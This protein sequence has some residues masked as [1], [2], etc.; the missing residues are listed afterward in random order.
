M[1]DYLGYGPDVDGEQPSIWRKPGDGSTPSVPATSGMYLAAH[2]DGN[3]AVV[4]V[5]WQAG[6][7]DV[8][9][10]GAGGTVDLRPAAGR[11]SI[12]AVITLASGDAVVLDKATR[13]VTATAADESAYAPTYTVATFREVRRYK[14]EADVPASVADGSTGILAVIP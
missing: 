12:R 6:A 7:V 11:G 4:S 2:L 14:S 3:P 1:A 8:T 9:A 13:L 5:R 10:L